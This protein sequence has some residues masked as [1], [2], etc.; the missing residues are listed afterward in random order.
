MALS[1]TLFGAAPAA[2][3]PAAV[4]EAL[5]ACGTSSGAGIRIAGSTLC[6]TGDIDRDSAARA[7]ALL[8]DRSLT[9]MVVTSDGGEV[10][11]AVRLARALRAR[12]L[13]LVVKSH[14]ISSCANFLFPAARTKA[15][16]PN[17]L[18]VF[19][20]GIAPGAFGGLFGDGEERELLALTRAFFREIGVDGSITYDPPYRRD[21]RSGVRSLAEEWTASPAALRRHGITG[22]VSLWWPST[23]AII[24]EAAS[25]GM[26]LGVVE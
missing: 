14:C 24:R 20:G 25:R 19:H 7:E 23:E 17:G 6:F 16:A 18:L 15:V 4:S 5:S 9:A 22:I 21:P 13:L 2:A 10:T 12:G 1:C 11:A 26:V 3:Q 8:A